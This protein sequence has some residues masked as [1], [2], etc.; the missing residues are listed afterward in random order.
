[1]SGSYVNHTLYLNQLTVANQKLSGLAAPSAPGD[2]TNKAYVDAAVIEAAA[3]AASSVT[4]LLDN[5]PTALNTL[6]ELSTALADDPSFATS[7]T[8]LVGNENIRALNAEAANSAAITAEAS[9]ARSAEATL[10]AAITAE[11][12]AARSAEATLTAAITAEASAARSAEAT[13]TAAITAEASRAQTAETANAAAITAEAATARSAE[14]ANAAAITAEAA[15]ATA[16][17]AAILSSL[18]SASTDSVAGLAAIKVYLQAHWDY[19]HANQ[20]GT[21]G[22]PNKL[23]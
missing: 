20:S 12:S 19:F 18:S 11:A 21:V 3:T 16:A 7:M 5:A 6:R 22:F 9:A 17:E 14:T 13:L 8:T 2:A 4:S 15:R 1:M 23:I 10:A